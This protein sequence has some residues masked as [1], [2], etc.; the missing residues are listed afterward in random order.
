[1]CRDPGLIRAI[2]VIDYVIQEEQAVE[3]KLML[4]QRLRRLEASLG[5]FLDCPAFDTFWKQFR[6]TMSVVQFRFR[7]L[8]FVGASRSGK[9]QR[10]SW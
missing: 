7:S 1:M 2:A 5:S 10:A 3:H 6:D 9:T 8:L 4:H